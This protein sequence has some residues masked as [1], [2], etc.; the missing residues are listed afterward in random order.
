MAHKRE[1]TRHFDSPT[2]SSIALERVR[3]LGKLA[4]KDRHPAVAAAAADSVYIII[5]MVA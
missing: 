5:I 1:G 2:F 4:L 3:E